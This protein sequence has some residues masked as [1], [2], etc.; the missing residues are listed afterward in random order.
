MIG[1]G[2]FD[3]LDFEGLSFRARA[4]RMW[5]AESN[6]TAAGIFDSQKPAAPPPGRAAAPRA[7][8]PLGSEPKPRSGVVPVTG[9]RAPQPVEDEE[10]RRRR[11]VMGSGGGAARPPVLSPAKESAA[12]RPVEVVRANLAGGSQPAVVKLASYA[13]GRARTSA[14]LTYQ[15]HQG[16]LALERQDGSL[17]QGKD[18]IQALV[19]QWQ[20]ESP[21]REP[22]KDVLSFT[23][24]ADRP[25]PD[26]EVRDALAEA[27]SG[28][29]HAWRSETR[30]ERTTVHV[31]MSAAS[32][33]RDEQGKALRIYDN[34]KSLGQ[35]EERVSEAFGGGEFKADGFVHGVE[36]AALRLLRLSRGGERPATSEWGRIL[37]SEEAARAEAKS[38]KRD[39]RSTEQ[40]DIAH[41]IFSAKPG[42]DKAAFLD[43]V[44]ATLDREFAGHDYVFA[45]HTNR[46]HIHV[47]AAVRMQSRYGDRLDPKIQDFQRW[48]ETLAEEARER[49]I[50]MEA[51]SR[52]EQANV[53]GYKLKD[54]R[55][56]ERGTAPESARRRVEAS[57]S[58]AIHI[59]TREEGR[60]R[61]NEVARGWAATAV[62]RAAGKEPP[63]AADTI[64]LYRAERPGASGSSAPLFA[65]ERH[66]AETLA[67]S[68]NGQVSYV[69][70]P[71]SR[72]SEVTPSRTNPDSFVLVSQELAAE[73]QQLDRSGRG[74]ILALRVIIATQPC[75][76]KP[77]E[78]LSNNRSEGASFNPASASGSQSVI[79]GQLYKIG[80]AHRAGDPNRALSK[81]V[82]LRS[83]D[84]L[85]HRIWSTSL[86]DALRRENASVGETVTAWLTE[87]AP[88][89]DN[90]TGANGHEVDAVQRG[91]WQMR[92]ER[93]GEAEKPQ[94]D[95]EPG[96]KEDNRNASE[97]Q[98]AQT[99]RPKRRP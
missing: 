56:V 67:A 70:V 55:R 66:V 17:V 40:R 65:R 2:V 32:S 23:F 84:G 15:S 62:A 64:R 97:R 43:A 31:A 71:R 50:P 42:T 38:W 98:R 90:P 14:L 44:R 99:F 92:I 22:S 93:T 46:A 59:P 95:S 21:S 74:R 83:Q 52:F 57:R 47:H 58:R 48:R 60:K 73:R 13:S 80:E 9:A 5:L 94:T 49:N 69:D 75:L 19:A 10:W 29:R 86:H 18:A 4:L 76:N 72:L 34:R 36:G 16:E 27:L 20:D 25:L 53:P 63:R 45:L 26:A 41:I 77:Q 24:A 28:H 30:G 51:V 35:L 81:F 96:A 12:T 6:A 39:L 78:S 3:G 82:E 91:V 8:R 88:K 85:V 33:Q 54:I 37:D 11:G 61:A 79:S 89:S 7:E 1:A 68:F 87:T